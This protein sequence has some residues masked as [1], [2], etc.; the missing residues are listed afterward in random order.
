MHMDDFFPNKKP[1][2][3]ENL[4]HRKEQFR[5]KRGGDAPGNGCG[6]NGAAPFM[7]SG[8]PA[9]LAAEGA[10]HGPNLPENRFFSVR[11]TETSV[12]SDHWRSWDRQAPIRQDAESHAPEEWHETSIRSPAEWQAQTVAAAHAGDGANPISSSATIQI[13]AVIAVPSFFFWPFFFRNRRHGR[14]S[15]IS[16]FNMDVRY[17]VI[18][19][20]WPGQNP[21][22]CPRAGVRRVPPAR[23]P[24]TWIGSP[25]SSDRPWPVRPGPC[26]DRP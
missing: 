20:P 11:E 1:H 2:G 3:K 14:R 6:E 7:R 24:D 21:G 16:H 18:G 23:P 4:Q 12:L 22:P 19:N 8:S 17:G 13:L 9:A 5:R 15:G 26:A 10:I 25:W